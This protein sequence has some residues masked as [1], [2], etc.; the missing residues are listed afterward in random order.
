MDTQVKKSQDDINKMSKMMEMIKVYGPVMGLMKGYKVEPGL[1]EGGGVES[2]IF[3]GMKGDH[4]AEGVR[5][6]GG[7]LGEKGDM[8]K[9]RKGRDT[10][11]RERVGEL[12]DR[13]RVR[14]GG[15]RAEGKENAK[16]TSTEEA[17]VEKKGSGDMQDVQGMRAI[18]ESDG[19]SPTE[20]KITELTRKVE[21]SDG[22]ENVGKVTRNHADAKR[23]KESG[24]SEKSE[25][26]DN[27]D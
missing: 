27:V 23:N 24:G 26:V 6:E 21:A 25:D 2:I 15:E 14:K 11:W 7:E 16:A 12:R 10:T 1:Y 20:W 13:G 19:P 5:V 9:I 17:H 22:S 3:F 18:H 8:G 4:R